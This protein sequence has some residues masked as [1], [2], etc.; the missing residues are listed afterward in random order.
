MIAQRARPRFEGRAWAWALSAT[1][2]GLA[3]GA[4]PLPLVLFGLGAAAF[5]LLTLIEPALAVVAMLAVA[6]LKTLIATEAP[7]A[8]PADLGQWALGWALGAWLL[9]RVSTRKHAPLPRT[10]LYAPLL[11]IMAGFAP[12]LLAAQD[13]GAWLS[14]MLKWAEML[15][16]VALVLDLGRTRWDWIA[17]GAVLAGTLQALLGLYEFRGGSGAP[18][19]WIAGFRHFR[20]FGTFGQPNPFSAFMG[21]TLPL[22]LGLAWGYARSAWARRRAARTAPAARHVATLAARGDLAPR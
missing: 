1:L 17:F 21:L 11:L 16:L 18:H 14:E 9:W 13:A 3:V 4:A 20:A 6:P 10:R 2:I 12:S 22:A 15:L 8:L 7:F 19:L 5:V